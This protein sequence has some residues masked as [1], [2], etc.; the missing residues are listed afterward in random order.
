[1]D[2]LVPPHGGRL[3]SVL[4]SP[5]MLA[6]E[7]ERA[8][9]LPT[10]EIT[11]REA[12]DLIM[13]AMGAF[14]PLCGFMTKADYLNVKQEMHL[15]DGTFWPIPITLSVNRERADAL[16]EGNEVALIDRE[17]HQVIGTQV[18]QEKFGY[19]KEEEARAVFGTTD[20]AHPGVDKL[21]RQGDILIGGPVRALSEGAYPERFGEYFARPE[22]T[23][24]VFAKRGWSQVAAFQLRNPMHRSHEY[25]TKIALEVSDGLFI[26]PLVGALKGDDIPAEVRMCCY[27]V[28]LDKYYPK[29]RVL[30]KVYPMEMRYAGPREALLHAVIRQN[31]GCSHLIVGRDHAGVGN[32]YGPFDAQEIFDSLTPEDLEIKPLKI[33]WTFYCYRCEGMASL[34]TCPHKTED[35]CLISGT[36]LRRQLSSGQMPPP[37]FSRP[38]ILEILINYYKNNPK[39]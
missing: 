27:E 19:D 26:H 28:L 13:M 32:Y 33:D 14:S 24:Q 2:K 29:N 18:I 30:L 4:I 38:E 7:K 12:S 5:D 16:K 8:E 36:E 22:E 10:V 9:T 21:F 17:S 34:K 15:L 23:R 3:T 39:E 6:A 25:C 35:R 37:E 20:R 1:M 31:F 11:S